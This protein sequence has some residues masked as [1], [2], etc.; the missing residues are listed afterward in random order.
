MRDAT[1]FISHAWGYNFLDLVRALHEHLKDKAHTV[2]WFDLFCL[3]QN[4]MGIKKDFKW[5]STTFKT[6]IKTMQN[7]LVLVSSFED[8]DKVEKSSA[9]T[10]AWCVFEMWCAIDTKCNFE[11]AFLADDHKQLKFEEVVEKIRTIDA[12]QCN[13][14]V[15]SELRLIK[16]TIIKYSG[17]MDTFNDI[18]RKKVA[19]QVFLYA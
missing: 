12:D 4:D 10:R 5:L 9:F 15:E 18:I 14:S 6:A 2:I 8:P 11:V 17:G 1:V 16:E 19:R 7:I 3:N 13:A